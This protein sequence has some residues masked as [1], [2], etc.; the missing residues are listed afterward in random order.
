MQHYIQ[1][2]LNYNFM[3]KNVVLLYKVR[4]EFPES[5]KSIYKDEFIINS[6]VRSFERIQILA[7]FDLKFTNEY[8]LNIILTDLWP[9]IA[10]R[11]TKTYIYST[12]CTCIKCLCD[13]MNSYRHGIMI[14]LK[15]MK[16]S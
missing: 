2:T 13:N 15:I 14:Y 3:G 4:N 7:S 5:Q 11:S 16:F 12:L 6:A 8:L 1:N 9:P 10:I